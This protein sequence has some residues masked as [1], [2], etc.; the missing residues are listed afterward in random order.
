MVNPGNIPA[1][2]AY[3]ELLPKPAGVELI[4]AGI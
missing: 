1:I 2:A 3:L 4:T